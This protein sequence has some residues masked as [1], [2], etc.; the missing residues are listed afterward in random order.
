MAYPHGKLNFLSSFSKN[1]RFRLEF[2]I[3]R[4]SLKNTPLMYT[5]LV[6]F[7]IGEKSALLKGWSWSRLSRK[8]VPSQHWGIFVQDGRRTYDGET[9]E[10]VPCSL[11]YFLLFIEF[12]FVRA[13]K[14]NNPLVNYKSKSSTEMTP[15]FL[16]A[17]QRKWSFNWF[18]NHNRIEVA[19]VNF[20]QSGI[21]PNDIWW[22]L[23]SSNLLA[24]AVE[25]P[26]VFFASNLLF[27]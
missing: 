4:N 1:S 21:L 24:I 20:F 16:V 11:A 9:S 3:K 2:E 6:R 25:V 12:S 5:V 18:T 8:T 23:L 13:C 7:Y 10:G 26:G 22:Q 19:V 14:I 17:M 27:H 15:F